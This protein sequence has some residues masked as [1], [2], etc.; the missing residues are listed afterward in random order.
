MAYVD[1]M[2]G[3]KAPPALATPANVESYRSACEMSEGTCRQLIR[4]C[5]SVAWAKVLKVCGVGHYLVQT[6][7]AT[8]E[9]HTERL[10]R[11]GE[12]CPIKA[13]YVT[14]PDAPKARPKTAD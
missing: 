8:M 10:L 6:E 7:T 14:L 13:G 1:G 5:G 4:S 9:L 11:V 2:D 12:M 3:S